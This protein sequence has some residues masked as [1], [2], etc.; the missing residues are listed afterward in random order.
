MKLQIQMVILT[1]AMLSG[2]AKLSAQA[3]TKA[4]VC[5][6]AR[7]PSSYKGRMLTLRG[8]INWKTEDLL[9]YDECSNGESAGIVLVLNERNV[10]PKPSFALL[11]NDSLRRFQQYISARLEEQ[12]AEPKNGVCIGCNWKYCRVDLTVTGRLDL[13]SEE[14]ARRG[15]GFGNAGRQRYRL[16][17]ESVGNP[18]AKEC[19]R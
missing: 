8:Q 4:E 5:A 16:V 1:L 19:E 10:E 3:I 11:E 9:I 6:V 2:T 13:V 14:E 18:V 7:H 17:A 12:P 15:K